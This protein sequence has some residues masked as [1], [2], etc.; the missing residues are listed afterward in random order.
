MSALAER[1]RA[2]LEIDPT[3]PALEFAGR[4]YTWG[5]LRGTVDD[6]EHALG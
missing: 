2:V 5:D 1:I 6:V 3:A 4:W